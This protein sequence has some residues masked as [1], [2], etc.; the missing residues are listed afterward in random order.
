MTSVWTAH[1]LA[2]LPPHPPQAP[3]ITQASVRPVLPGHDVWDMWPLADANSARADVA[4]GTLW[5]ALCAPQWPDPIDRHALA[6][7]RLLHQ[8]GADWRDCGNALLDGDNPGSREWSGSAVL[9]NGGPELTL[10][11]T[12]AGR[13]G[14]ASPTFEQR[15]FQI[16]GRLEVAS[17]MPTIAWHGAPTESV[18]SDDA[19]YIR[20]DQ[21]RGEPGQIKAFRDPAYFRDP[22]DGNEYLLFA[23]SLKASLHAANGIVGLAQAP[24]AGRR[25]WRLKPPLLSA[26]G[27]NNELERPHLLHLD[28][29]YY[30][31]WSTQRHTFAQGGPSGPNG[32]YGMVAE[33]MAG[34]YRPLN[35]G[36]LVITNPASEPTQ[37]YSWWV[38]PD[39]L[40]TSF[41]DY[42]G[43]G[44]RALADH[45]ELVR[46][47]FGGTPAP[48][49]RLRLQGDRAW[50]AST[51]A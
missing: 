27:L 37:A 35:G 29:H 49:L 17:G 38:M 45:P 11:F 34:P 25:D 3:L 41:I 26:D 8:R 9:W 20:A 28:G 7:I 40:V 13:R 19:I 48:M 36:G 32:L 14:E 39:G 31:F 6:R 1:D 21:A 4:G 10:F 5:F 46:I 16:D 15:L 30:L 50:L 44:G 2:A 23:A 42:W 33:Q 24:V 18:A 12:A 22:A 47:Q 43:M 51:T